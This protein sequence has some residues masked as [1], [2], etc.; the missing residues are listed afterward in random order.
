ME[1]E[2]VLIYPTQP[3]QDWLK[4]RSSNLQ[5]SSRAKFYFAITRA[6]HSVGIVFNDNIK[7][8]Y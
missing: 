7:K 1:F 5:P 2:R 8:Y 3:F 6:K 4:N